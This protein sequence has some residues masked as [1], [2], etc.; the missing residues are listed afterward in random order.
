MPYTRPYRRFYLTPPSIPLFV[1]S[2]VLA[3]L[4]CLVV[5]GHVGVFKAA[6]AFTVLIIA[7]LLLAI[8]VLVRGL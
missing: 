2:I 1:A 4:A 3:L 5:Y 8:G 7:Y 6:Y